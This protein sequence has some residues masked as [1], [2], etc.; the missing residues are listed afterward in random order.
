MEQYF[1][2]GTVG[3]RSARCEGIFNDVID[4]VT[5]WEDSFEANRVLEGLL[6]MLE[7]YRDVCKKV[8]MA[9][10]VPQSAQAC[11]PVPIRAIVGNGWGNAPKPVKAILPNG[12]TFKSFPSIH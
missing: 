4:E 6:K 11:P 3:V 1:S 5:A 8:V 10:P 9:K 12:K 2:R 7:V